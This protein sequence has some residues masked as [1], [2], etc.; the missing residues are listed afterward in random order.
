M[1]Y[2]RKLKKKQEELKI[3]ADREVASTIKILKSET[4]EYI[5]N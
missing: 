1:E 2:E 5:Q 3:E 4:D